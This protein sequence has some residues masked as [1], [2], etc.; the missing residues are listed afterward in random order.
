MSE[1]RFRPALAVDATLD[2]ISG[3][4]VKNDAFYM[5]RKYDGIRGFVLNGTLVSRTLKPIRNQFIQS[6]IGRPEFEGLDGELVVG[7]PF[8]QNVMQRSNSGVMSR[9]GEPD[10]KFYVFDKYDAPGLYMDRLEYLET[11]PWNDKPGAE[12][13]ELVDQHLVTSIALVEHLERRFIEE[14]YEGA[15]LRWVASPYKQNRSTLI[16]R[17]MLKLK[18][19]M[20]SEGTIIGFEELMHNDNEATVDAR[21]LTTR[22]SHKANKRPGGTLGKLRVQDLHR[23]EW[24]P[25]VGTGFDSALRQ[26]IW[27]NQEKYLGKIISY[28][29][30]F[31][32]TKDQPR[33]PVF[34]GFRD[35]SDISR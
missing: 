19:F 3:M 4:L 32:G 5:S 14:H 29:Y 2:D 18:Q 12:F 30:Q 9:A 1:A 25:A 17:Y 6:I 21:G 7:E 11:L 35:P 13:I 34:M 23:S 10:F 33:H 31:I 28:K 16:E 8:G 26:E 22:S 15:I 27:D 20:D 24:T